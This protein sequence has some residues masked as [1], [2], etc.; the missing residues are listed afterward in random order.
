MN[1]MLLV[2]V[3]GKLGANL[4]LHSLSFPFPKATIKVRSLAKSKGINLT[5][6]KDQQ[7]RAEDMF[8]SWS[9]R[10]VN[11][12][13]KTM[14]VNIRKTSSVSVKQNQNVA[15][16]RSWTVK[17][18]C[19]SIVLIHVIVDKSSISSN[20]FCLTSTLIESHLEVLLK[21]GLNHI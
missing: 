10:G 12:A 14:A 17:W 15:C 3:N 18:S 9:P 2:F 4:T 6:F 5:S 7:A 13:L 1:V 19:T 20:D 16:M 8:L 21:L 11:V